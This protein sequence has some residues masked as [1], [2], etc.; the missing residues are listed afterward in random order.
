MQT[1][2]LRETPTRLP[3]FADYAAHANDS[4]LTQVHATASTAASPDAFSRTPLFGA[5]EKKRVLLAPGEEVVVVDD[6]DGY[7]VLLAGGLKSSIPGPYGLSGQPVSCRFDQTDYTVFL[8]LLRYVKGQLGV[9]VEFEPYKFAKSL[10]L[11]DSETNVRVLFGCIARMAETRL[12]VRCPIPG[13][14]GH[15]DYAVGRLVS[16]VGYSTKTRKYSIQLDPR[17][18]MLFKPANFCALDWEQRLAIKGSLGKWLHAELSSHE[19]GRWRW[20]HK[21]QEAYGSKSTPALFKMRLKEAAAEV[22][23]VTGWDLRFE[24]PAKG[25]NEKLVCHK[26]A[27]H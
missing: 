25:A 11:Q 7:Q 8:G 4:A 21:L 24:K 12:A 14:Q 23:A 20:T 13:S 2:P 9:S 10:G 22:A 3:S 27:L 17:L 1:S 26:Q 15:F 19:S 16:S 18:A 6:P 5:S